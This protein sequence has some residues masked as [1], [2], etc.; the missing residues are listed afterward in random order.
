[1]VEMAMKTS[2]IETKMHGS[3]WTVGMCAALI[4]ASMSV[5]GQERGKGPVS[6]AKRPAPETEAPQSRPLPDD[7]RLLAIHLEFVKSAEKLGKEYE[8]VKD[9][10]KARSVY[11]E[12]LK[13]V[14]QYKPAAER[15]AAMRAHEANAQT[16]TVSVKATEGWQDSGIELLPGKPVSITATGSWTF[17]LQL[18]TNAEGLTIPPELRDFNPGCLVG[19]I[20]DP[21]DSENN[22]PFVVG[23]SKRLELERGGKLFLRM[24][25]TDARDNDG[26]LKVEIRGTFKGG[27]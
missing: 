23:S 20:Q 19:R 26:A 17:H 24:Y 8:G 22:K 9:W 16:A 25:D 18:E 6:K 12:I 5:W 7:K 13:L 10:G 11:E 3:V 2:G 27:K 14:P 4:I 21:S 15:L 1:M